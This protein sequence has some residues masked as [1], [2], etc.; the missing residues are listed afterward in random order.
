MIVPTWPRRVWIFFHAWK[1]A[2]H[3][4]VGYDGATLACGTCMGLSD[5]ENGLPWHMMISMGSTKERFDDYN[6]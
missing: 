1:H 2:D 3:V 4:M 5:P 6:E